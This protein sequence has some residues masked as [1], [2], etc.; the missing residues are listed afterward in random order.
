MVSR[1]DSSASEKVLGEL[2]ASVRLIHGYERLRIVFTTERVIVAHV[3]KRGIGTGATASMFGRMGQG[4]EDIILTGRERVKTLGK[5]PQ[6]ILEM[7][8]ENFYIPYS[9]IVNLDCQDSRR[10][11][12][13]TPNDKFDLVSQ[14][15]VAPSLL[16]ELHRVLGQRLKVR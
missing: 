1:D 13:I 16:D 9:E 12:I 3:G 6:Q 5:A 10:L 11:V 4:L 2:F 14:T 7:D 15:P 8:K